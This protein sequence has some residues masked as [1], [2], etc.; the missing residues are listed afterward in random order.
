MTPQGPTGSHG[1]PQGPTGSH[2]VPRDPTEAHGTSLLSFATVLRCRRESHNTHPG[3]IGKIGQIQSCCRWPRRDGGHTGQQPRQARDRSS[4]RKRAV[5]VAGHA[6]AAGRR[7]ASRTRRRAA[8]H[9]LAALPPA[10]P[11]IQP[12]HPWSHH[13]LRWVITTHHP[14]SHNTQRWAAGRC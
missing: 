8:P 4:R 13:A 2:R 5:G 7:P 12:H 14:W 9:H 1:A 6:L 10:P 3:K 11:C